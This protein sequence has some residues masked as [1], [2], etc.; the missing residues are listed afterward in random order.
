MF[1]IESSSIATFVF[2]FKIKSFGHTIFQPSSEWPMV[3]WAQP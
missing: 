1:E 2:Q 3:L